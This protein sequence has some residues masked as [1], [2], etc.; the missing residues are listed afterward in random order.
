MLIVDAVDIR[1]KKKRSEQ[2]DIELVQRKRGLIFIA[3]PSN[4]YPTLAFGG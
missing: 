4:E 1:Q 3:I 2:K